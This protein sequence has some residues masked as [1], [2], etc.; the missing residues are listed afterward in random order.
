MKATLLIKSCW[1]N[2]ERREAV[3]KTW[4]PTIDWADTF[5]VLGRNPLSYGRFNPLY[6]T[7]PDTIGVDTSDGFKDLSTK[8]RAAI[9]WT[10]CQFDDDVLIVVDDDT[11]V[12]SRRLQRLARSCDPNDYLGLMRNHESWAPIPY[13]QGSAFLLGRQVI[14]LAGKTMSANPGPDDVGLGAALYGTGARFV[15]MG[16]SVFHV[17]PE[18]KYISNFNTLATTHKCLPAAMYQMHCAFLSSDKMSKKVWES[19][20]LETR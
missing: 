1:A 2:F 20:Y 18:P 17:G 6:T 5:F 9:N 11:Y 3:R 8:L 19:T 15:D 4:L 13:M 10:R 12:H 14:S 7:E 16:E